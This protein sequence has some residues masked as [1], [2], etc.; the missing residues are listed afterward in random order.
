MKRTLRLDI[1]SGDTTCAA[2]PGVT[3]P[4]IRVSNFGML[5]SCA[6]F[7]QGRQLSEERGWVQRHPVCI[8]AEV[9]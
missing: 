6:L 2:S 1:V 3:C 8:A 4:H 5:W 9:K 7:E